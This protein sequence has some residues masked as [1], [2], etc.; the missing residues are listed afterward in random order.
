MTAVDS[1]SGISNI[2]YSLRLINEPN[3]ILIRW[4]GDEIMKFEFWVEEFCQT[5]RER[6]IDGETDRQIQRYKAPPRSEPK[7]ASCSYHILREEGLQRW[8]FSQG[9]IQH[10]IPGTVE[11][12]GKKLE[13][14][15]KFQCRRKPIDMGVKSC[16]IE[17][18]VQWTSSFCK[19][20]TW[21][22]FTSKK[23]QKRWK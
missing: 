12:F 13:K 11:K 17:I 15:G 6:R 2:I 20:S 8:I 16:E 22:R 14:F 7:T 5:D 10:K 1:C 23:P 18:A 21:A 19:I 3:F 9:F 4:A